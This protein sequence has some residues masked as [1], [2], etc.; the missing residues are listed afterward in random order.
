MGI[1]FNVNKN[2]ISNIEVKNE[3]IFFVNSDSEDQEKLVIKLINRDV[4]VEDFDP[5]QNIKYLEFKIDNSFTR[6]SFGDLHECYTEYIFKNCPLSALLILTR[7]TT[8]LNT[9]FENN[10][11][12]IFNGEFAEY[13][14]TFEGK[15]SNSVHRY[16]YSNFHLFHLFTTSDSKLSKKLLSDELCG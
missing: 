4:T 8:F 15:D 1:C 3:K 6:G 10:K 16:T 14:S 7:N 13:F 11:V 12:S 2:K 5:N 9:F